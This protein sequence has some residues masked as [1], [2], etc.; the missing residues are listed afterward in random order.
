M[1]TVN[2]LGTTYY[3]AMSKNDKPLETTKSNRGDN[4][5]LVSR[6]V[7]IKKSGKTTRQY[8]TYKNFRQFYKHYKSI[9][10]KKNKNFY[11]A[12]TNNCIIIFCTVCNVFKN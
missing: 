11:A 6:E 12:G 9:K 2:K 1:P 8:A 4:Q 7:I 10:E 5:F 3:F